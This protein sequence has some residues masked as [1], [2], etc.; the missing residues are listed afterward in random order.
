MYMLRGAKQDTTTTPDGGE[1]RRERET[2]V[3]S[4]D[5]A[6]GDYAVKIMY[7]EGKS[8][9]AEKEGVENYL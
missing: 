4:K 2:P 5:R 6:G 8:T 3:R 1:K 9:S 7:K